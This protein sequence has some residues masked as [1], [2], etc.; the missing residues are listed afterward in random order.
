MVLDARQ[1]LWE[2]R[3]PYGV[4]EGRRRKR[5]GMIGLT[6]DVS[7]GVEDSSNH[8]GLNVEALRFIVCS[9][10]SSTSTFQGFHL[11]IPKIYLY[12]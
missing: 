1:S 5:R 12:D 7:G 4:H 8:L 11:A 2:G 10:S 9:N 3:R 6:V